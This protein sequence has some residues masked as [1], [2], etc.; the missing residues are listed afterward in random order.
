MDRRE[1]L[2]RTALITGYALSASTIAGVL[3][4]CQPEQ[5]SPLDEWQPAYF[6]KE[7]GLMIA[8]IAERI[9][10]RTD[11]PGAQDVFVHEFIDLMVKDCR[12]AEDQA[13]FS[14]GLAELMEM[15]KTTNGKAFLDCSEEEQLALL[16][17]QDK[18]ARQLVGT[19]PYLDEEDYPFFL[20]LKEL[21]LTGYFTSEQIGTEVLAYLPVPG[22]YEG[23]MPYEAG[24]PVWSL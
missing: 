23:C 2:K 19:N 22:G 8:E 1:A 3:Q 12:K 16:N 20:E 4:G 5:K 21:V 10:P 17:Q 15:C 9:L 11:I 14:K 24:T 6:T 13:R 7:E 18:A